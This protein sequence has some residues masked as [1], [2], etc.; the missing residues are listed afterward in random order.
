MPTPHVPMVENVST[1]STDTRAIVLR[2]TLEMTAMSVSYS[3]SQFC[4][5]MHKLSQYS[6]HTTLWILKNIYRCL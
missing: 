2:D 5:Q 3:N 6:S 4:S 1:T